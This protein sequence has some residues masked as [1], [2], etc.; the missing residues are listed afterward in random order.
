MAI[1]VVIPGRFGNARSTIGTYARRRMV[2]LIVLASIA[3]VLFLGAGHVV[4][5]RGGAP[6]SAPAVRPAAPS[7]AGAADLYIVQPG[8]TLWSIGERFHGHTPL[9]DYVDDLVAANGGTTLQI[10]QPLA[11]P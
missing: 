2:V 11:L 5:N 9:V 1:A 10:A 8:D 6:A 4:A 7:T 3:L